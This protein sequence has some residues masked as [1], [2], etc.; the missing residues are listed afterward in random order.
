MDPNNPENPESPSET[1]QSESLEVVHPDDDERLYPELVERWDMVETAG[2]DGM[3]AHFD[4]T[5]EEENEENI[6]M[7]VDGN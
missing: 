1:S 2:C 4:D 5:D 3:P 6:N 7:G